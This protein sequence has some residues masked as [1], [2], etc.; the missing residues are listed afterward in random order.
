[1]LRHFVRI[2]V[3]PVLVAGVTLLLTVCSRN[4]GAQG[5]FGSISGTVIDPSGGVVAGATVKV[6]NIDTNVTT[7]WKTNSA[8]VYIATSLNPGNYRVE[9]SMT[10]F[11]T[12]VANNVLLEVNSNPKVILTLSVG[13]V[14]ETVEVTAE[15]TPILQTQQTDLGQTVSST[16]LEQLPTQSGTGRSPYNFLVLAPGVSQQFG[17][18][19]GGGGVG[20]CGNDGNVRISGSRP[21]NDDN[22]LD[23]TSITPPVFGGQGVHP[24]VEAIQEF[25]IEQNSMSAEYGKA[26]GAIIIQVSKSG[27]DH[28]HGSAYAYNRN[29]KL[30]AK[31]FF[32]DPG[33]PK[34]PFTYNE[35]GGSIG[36]P[37]IK[38]KFFFFTD[39]EAIRSHGTTPSAGVIVPDSNFRSGN[40]GTLCSEGFTNGVCNNPAHQIYFPG[41][42]NPVPNNVITSISPVS[43]AIEEVWPTG[44]TAVGPG[45]ESLT[46][47]LPNSTSLNRFNPRVDWNLSQADHI[48]G[49]VHTEYG[50]FHSNLMNP[51]PSGRQSSRAANY[52]ITV[53][54]TH[55][56]VQPH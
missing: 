18:S 47:N 35:F 28:F 48:F 24:T 2:W 29:Q 20:G 22:I 55:T 33:Q 9:A 38:S 41:T 37:V 45:E 32:V 36:G 26:G 30:D 7:T 12:A 43:A 14:T 49:A 1:M 17:C 25:R 21:R 46:V 44:G 16:R 8:G 31:N 10:G 11:K 19:G 40:L 53:G 5:L 23:G 4:L 27:T 42:A 6:T 13:Q 15:N 34:N 50:V 3:L 54:E 56:L 51:G 52:A 39:Y